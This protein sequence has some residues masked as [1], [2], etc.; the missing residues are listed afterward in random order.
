MSRP[1][2]GR[3]KAEDGRLDVAI[4]RAVRGILDVEPPAGLRG[5]VMHRIG[6][7]TEGFAASEESFVASAFR[8]KAAW[9]AAPLAAAAMLVL[10]VLMPSESGRPTVAPAAKAAND[11]YLPPAPL[12]PRAP[13][14]RPPILVAQGGTRPSRSHQL[15]AA[16]ALPADE[17]FEQ[18]R[19]EALSGPEPLAVDRLAGPPAPSVNTLGV[20]P[21][22]IRALEV[23]ALTETPPE[24]R[25]E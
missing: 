16:A 3:R 11:V 8:R 4:D 7:P 6:R 1:Q 13:E 15:I 5:R 20:A 10:A 19:V 12:G 18:A 9:V 23:T 24:R 2:D 22:Q 25:E 14:A 17:S 21:I